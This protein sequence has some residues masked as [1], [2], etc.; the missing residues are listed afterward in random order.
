MSERYP[1]DVFVDLMQMAC[2]DER[3]CPLFTSD[4]NLISYDGSHLTKEGA[5]YLGQ[6][7]REHPLIV[8]VLDLDR[9]N[10]ADQGPHGR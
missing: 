6:K 2:G 7:L 8:D 9:M 1:D 3:D 4:L 10:V 5:V